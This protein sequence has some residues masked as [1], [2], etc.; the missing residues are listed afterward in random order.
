MR[1]PAGAE[2]KNPKQSSLAQVYKT[3]ARVAKMKGENKK[4][5]IQVALV[6]GTVLEVVTVLDTT[7]AE[8][9]DLVLHRAELKG[10]LRLAIQGR[11]LK[12]AQ[13]LAAAGVCQGD[14]L[15]AVVVPRFQLFSTDRAFAVLKADGSVIAWGDSQMGGVIPNETA[16]ELAGDVLEVFANKTS[17]AAMKTDGSVIVWGQSE[18]GGM[19][20]DARQKALKTGVKKISRLSR[21]SLRSRRMG[22]SCAGG[23]LSLVAILHSWLHSFAA[24]W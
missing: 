14:R 7:V 6:S 1:H 24:A 3:F 4:A 5:S 10:A 18:T 9:S 15:S 19:V 16:R 23:H 8:I 20:P 2:R 22:V 12:P 17:F 13:T 21:L 11:V